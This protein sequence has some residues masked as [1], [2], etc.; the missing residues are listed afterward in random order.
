MG[1]GHTVKRGRAPEN[2]HVLMGFLG[3]EKRRFQE[4]RSCPGSKRNGND[5]VYCAG[6]LEKKRSDQIRMRLNTRD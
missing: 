6:A 3:H 1:T 5:C 4:D 2:S